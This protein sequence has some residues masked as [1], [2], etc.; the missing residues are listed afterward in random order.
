MTND[1]LY[2]IEEFDTTGWVLIHQND[3]HLT[4]EQCKKKV[5]DYIAEGYNPN[6]L[7]VRIE[8]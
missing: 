1:V 6:R 4:K 2:R 8:E 3:Q 5:N 7:R